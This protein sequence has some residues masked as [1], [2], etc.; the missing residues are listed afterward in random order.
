MTTK[1]YAALPEDFI[2]RM[3]N[4][5]RVVTGQM[6]GIAFTSAYEGIAAGTMH[7]QPIPVLEGEADDTD[8]ALNTLPPREKWA[9]S[10]FWSREGRSLR[11]HARGRAIDPHTF[12][13]W[14]IR[15]HDMLKAELA[16]QLVSARH[17]AEVNAHLSAR[18]A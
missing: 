7:D 2:R 9:V 3:R 12:E 15:G 16:R 1:I 13:A 17:A 10:E 6:K 5:A 4:W 18:A 14:T 8:R 11:Q